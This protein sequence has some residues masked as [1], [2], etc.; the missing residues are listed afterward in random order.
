MKAKIN[1][2]LAALVWLGAVVFSGP[3]ALA[4]E[5]VTLMSHDSFNASKEVIEAFEKENQATVKF[6]KSGDAG[7]ALVQAI[8]SKENPLADAF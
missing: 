4:Q 1:V 8:L 5:T 2:L 3:P 6:L 7:A